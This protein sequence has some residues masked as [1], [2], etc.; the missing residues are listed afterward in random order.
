MGHLHIGNVEALHSYIV[1]L[2]QVFDKLFSGIPSLCPKFLS[3]LAHGCRF[4]RSFDRHVL[5][6]IGGGG[7]QRPATGETSRETLD[8]VHGARERQ[9]DL[10]AVEDGPAERH[11]DLK[12]LVGTV[13]VAGMDSVI[14]VEPVGNV[15]NVRR[16]VE[17]IVHTA[18]AGGCARLCDGAPSAASE[19]FGESVGALGAD[20]ALA[21]PVVNLRDIGRAGAA[22]DDAAH[23]IAEL[24]ETTNVI[25]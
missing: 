12:A 24:D 2:G 15:L 13:E 20:A 19:Y 5:L 16:H 14:V 9:R 18:A 25:G 4:G 23:A 7:E 10:S 17:V 1:R 22:L 11:H 21:P 8:F 3:L 6:G